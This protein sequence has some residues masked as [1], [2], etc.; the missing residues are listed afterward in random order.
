MREPLLSPLNAVARPVAGGQICYTLPKLL[1]KKTNKTRACSLVGGVWFNPVLLMRVRRQ[2]KTHLHKN[3]QVL[4]L[5]HL[6]G[7]LKAKC[8]FAPKCFTR[9][10]SIQTYVQTDLEE[11]D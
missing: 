2:N 8:F 3:F 9:S 7:T 5:L 6:Y 11:Q 1:T 4:S 10:R